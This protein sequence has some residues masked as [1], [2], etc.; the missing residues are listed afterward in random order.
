MTIINIEGLDKVALLKSLWTNASFAGGNHGIMAMLVHTA[1]IEFNSEEAKKILEGNRKYVDYFQ[2]KPIKIN[3]SG[4]E[5]DTFLYDMDHGKGLGEKVINEF[6]GATEL[7]KIEE[8]GSSNSSGFDPDASLETLG[9]SGDIE[10][11]TS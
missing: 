5:I 4:P 9:C 1:P 3:F 2:N 10:G 11:S 7:M 8:G 6:K